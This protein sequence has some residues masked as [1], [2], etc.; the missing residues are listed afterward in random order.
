MEILVVLR[1]VERK[2]VQTQCPVMGNFIKARGYVDRREIITKII[3]RIH[4]VGKDKKE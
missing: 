3:M 1:N 4:K 2:Y